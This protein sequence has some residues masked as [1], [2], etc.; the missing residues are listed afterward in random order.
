MRW[1]ALSA[2]LALAFL[3]VPLCASA[4]AYGIRGTGMGIAPAGDGFGMA[5]V[6]EYDQGGSRGSGDRGLH[7]RRPASQCEIGGQPCAP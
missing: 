2:L 4:K 3:L 5:D 7:V 1:R 6:R